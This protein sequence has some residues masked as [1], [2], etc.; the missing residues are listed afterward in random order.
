[1]KSQT[2]FVSPVPR[3]S[4]QGRHL[5]TYAYTDKKGILKNTKQMGKNKE[6]GCTE[7]LMF[8]CDNINNKLKTGLD[9]RIDNPYYVDTD[10]PEVI[11]D[12]RDVLRSSLT[13]DESW[14]DAILDGVIR[15]EKIALQTLY[16]LRDGT[17]YNFYTSSVKHRK[18]SGNS[19]F[20]MPK[21]DSEHTFLEQF[22]VILYDSTNRFSS[23]SAR[24]RLSMQLLRNHP[25]VARSKEEINT[26]QHHYYISSEEEDAEEQVKREKLENKAIAKLSDILDRKLRDKYIV[27]SL[28]QKEN[29]IFAVTGDVTEIAVDRALNDYIKKAKDKEYAISQFMDIASLALGHEEEQRKLFVKYIMRKAIDNHLI[30]V[31]NMKYK[32]TLC[33]RDE[34]DKMSNFTESGMFSTLYTWFIENDNK[35]DGLEDTY[36]K[37]LIEALE[38][39]NIKYIRV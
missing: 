37:R 39:R 16:E 1:M 2:M 6:L 4:A 10:K 3:L 26:T 35:T 11:K 7:T 25:L 17:T 33:E 38:R 13:L 31:K 8:V 36:Y 22:K 27:A 34:E 28:L 9:V 21:K 15:S 18:M 20:T 24:G 32:F 29:G 30:L 19:I 14:T 23:D 12:K 5:Q